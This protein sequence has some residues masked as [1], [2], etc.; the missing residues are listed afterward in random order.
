M[1][2]L[3]T[4]STMHGSCEMRFNGV[5]A[6]TSKAIVGRRELAVVNMSIVEDAHNATLRA[7]QYYRLEGPVIGGSR[8]GGPV[9]YADKALTVELDGLR[10]SFGTLANSI[11]AAKSLLL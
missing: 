5:F 7:P 6:L 9:L 2:Y 11:A 4:N 10:P 1:S 3:P 8:P